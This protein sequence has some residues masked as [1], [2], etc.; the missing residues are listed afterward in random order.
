MKNWE[1]GLVTLG[2]FLVCTESASILCNSACLT[3]DLIYCWR[4]HYR[5][6]EQQSL[7]RSD[8][9][10]ILGGESGIAQ[11]SSGFMGGLGGAR[12]PLNL[13]CPTPWYM[14]GWYKISLIPSK[15]RL[16]PHSI[17]IFCRRLRQPDVV[18]KTSISHE[19]STASLSDWQVWKL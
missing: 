13:L 6:S 15:A 11:V 3:W 19:W 16:Y 7:P 18:L 5:I 10:L 4:W 8:Y 9:R 12:A 1:K 14:F 2:K 17:K